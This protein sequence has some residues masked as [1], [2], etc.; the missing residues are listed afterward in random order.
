MFYFADCYN[1]IALPHAYECLQLRG[2][3]NTL[4]IGGGDYFSGGALSR[5][6]KGDLMLQVLYD[7]NVKVSAI[8]NHEF[9]HGVKRF[10]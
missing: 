1:A 9:D 2:N 4:V 8:G 7:M 10:L 5:I 3:E 6:D